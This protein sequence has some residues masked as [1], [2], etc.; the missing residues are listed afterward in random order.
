MIHDPAE[1]RAYECDAFTAYRCPPLAVVLPAL[2]RGGRGG[3]ARLP[4]RAACRWCRAAPAPASRAASLPTA[5]SV[6]LGVAR[7]TEVL[8]VDFDNR[9]IRVQAG[10]TNLSVTGAVEDDG[11]LL[12]ARPVAASSPAPSPATS[13]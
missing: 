13:R 3:H 11:L 12:R 4:R 10:R 9:L 2:D 1:V 5:D 6:M 8:E 7:L